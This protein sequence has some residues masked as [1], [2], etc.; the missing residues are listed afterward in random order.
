[1]TFR[2]WPPRW[3]RAERSRG[4]SRVVREGLLA[5]EGVVFRELLLLQ[6]AL[7]FNLVLAGSFKV[8]VEAAKVK[9]EVY[10][11]ATGEHRN[12]VR[13]GDEWVGQHPTAEAPDHRAGKVGEDKRPGDDLAVLGANDRGD[14]HEHR[15]GANKAAERCN[16]TC[17]EKCTFCWK[18][19]DCTDLEEH[20]GSDRAQVR[21]HRGRCLRI[22]AV[23]IE[24]VGVV[25]PKNCTQQVRVDEDQEAAALGHHPREDSVVAPLPAS[26]GDGDVWSRVRLSRAAAVCPTS[27]LGVGAHL[28]ENVARHAHRLDD[29]REAQSSD[30]LLEDRPG[31]PGELFS[32]LLHHPRSKAPRRD[33][34]VVVRQK[35]R[36]RRV[37][38]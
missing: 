13:G 3:H 36:L 2:A 17:E 14:D 12:E 21:L 38:L 31:P 9:L 22:A 25:R 18:H 26:K 34:R 19:E 29:G 4:A 30:E 6:L 11:D 27:H 20:E 35:D 8:S 5:M 28:H 37:L 16:E 32:P 7:Y 15:D 10:A 23:F 1:M 33:G 24:C